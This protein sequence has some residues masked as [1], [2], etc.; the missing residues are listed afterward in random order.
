M[1]VCYSG[2]FEGKLM[3]VHHTHDASLWPPQGVI[4][5]NAVA[6]AQGEAA[7]RQGFRLRW[8][9]NAEHMPPRGLPGIAGRASNTWLIDYQPLIEQ[10]LQDLIDWVEQG[11]EP[12]GNNYVYQ[13]GKVIL[14]A[15]AAE[16][17]G[18]QAVVGVTANGAS[19]AAVKVGVPVVLKVSAELSPGSGTIVGVEWD[20]DGSGTFP[21][22]HFEIDGTATSVT[23]TKTHTYDQPGTYFATSLVHSHR[24]GDV[25]AT[26]RRVPNLAQARIVVT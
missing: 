19:R 1:G 14:P 21:F 6:A 7:M 3:W 2:Q 20:F 8:A 24:D 25:K 18:I 26:S 22:A 13:D 17:G 16:R 12:A 15:T 23:R 11:V 9:D 10:S 5:A 4:Y